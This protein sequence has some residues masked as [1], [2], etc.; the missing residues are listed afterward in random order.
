MT[1]E[2]INLIHLIS[3]GKH[4]ETRSREIFLKN[5]SSQETF[6]GIKYASKRKGKVAYD[7]VGS[8]IKN[9]FP[10]FALEGEVGQRL[11]K[12]IEKNVHSRHGYGL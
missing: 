5:C 3:S 12:Q 4:P 1:E 2:R 7:S 8:P 10:V 11:Y 9:A 6:E